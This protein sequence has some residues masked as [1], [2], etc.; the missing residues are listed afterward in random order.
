MW[1]RVWDLGFRVP[2][3]GG[4]LGFTFVLSFIGG[5]CIAFMVV[6]RV[7][8]LALQFKVLHICMCLMLSDEGDL[9]VN[10]FI[11]LLFQSSIHSINLVWLVLLS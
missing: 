6:S 11:S 3:F 7:C 10:T 2:R 1:S 4:E 5:S 9:G 8:D